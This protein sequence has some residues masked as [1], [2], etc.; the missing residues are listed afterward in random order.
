MKAISEINLDFAPGPNDIPAIYPSQECAA[1]LS[2][3]IHRMLDHFD[4]TYE[5]FTQGKDTDSIYLDYTKVFD[6][7]DLDLLIL[8]LKLY[9]FHTL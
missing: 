6:K 9:G 1:S 5:G 2:V 7:V 8:K 3:P 4:D